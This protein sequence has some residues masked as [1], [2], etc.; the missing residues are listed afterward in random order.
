MC[1]R[2]CACIRAF[3]IIKRNK[4]TQSNVIKVLYSVS[5]KNVIP[6]DQKTV[7]IIL[8]WSVHI[9]DSIHV[10]GIGKES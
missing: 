3:G 4:Q 8:K 9:W 5:F 10:W 7:S 1:V 6:L 2:A